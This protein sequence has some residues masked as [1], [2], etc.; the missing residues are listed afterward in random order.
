MWLGVCICKKNYKPFIALLVLAYLQTFGNLMLM[1]LKIERQR[2]L[3]YLVAIFVYLQS[4][5]IV[6]MNN[7]HR[8]WK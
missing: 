7:L 5:I 4:I 2:M 6:H 1:G 3:P 8:M